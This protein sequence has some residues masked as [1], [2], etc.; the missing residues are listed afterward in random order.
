[1]TVS[2]KISLTDQRSVDQ[3]RPSPLLCFRQFARQFR[4]LGVEARGP[5][6]QLA[7][8]FLPLSGEAQFKI[9]DQRP[10]GDGANVEL[11]GQLGRVVV[12]HVETARCFCPLAVDPRLVNLVFRPQPPFYRFSRKS[13]WQAAQVLFIAWI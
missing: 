13:S 12:E 11:L 10:Y 3:L 7:A 6:A 4:P 5:A 9:G 1:M 8:P 2:G